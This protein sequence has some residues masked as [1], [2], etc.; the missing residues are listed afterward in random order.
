MKL[1]WVE[2]EHSERVSDDENRHVIEHLGRRGA[3]A[4]AERVLESILMGTDD[5]S[6]MTADQVRRRLDILVKG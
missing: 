4:E 6:A 2:A 5:A 1:R 3:L